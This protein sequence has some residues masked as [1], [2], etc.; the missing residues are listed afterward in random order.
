VYQPKWNRDSYAALSSLAENAAAGD[1]V[2][3]LEF[4]PDALA[5]PN[6]EH[7]FRGA[8]QQEICALLESFLVMHTCFW[9]AGAFG[10]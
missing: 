8:A 6:V 7:P 10:L 2:P 5:S 3:L 9:G 4:E 1:I